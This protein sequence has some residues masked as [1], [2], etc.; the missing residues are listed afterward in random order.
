MNPE[1]RN[2]NEFL[3]HYHI[4]IDSLEHI[5]RGHEIALK[6]LITRYDALR[7]IHDRRNTLS[8]QMRLDYGK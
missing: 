6:G 5:I 1:L 4:P 8:N 2:D 3:E 7:E